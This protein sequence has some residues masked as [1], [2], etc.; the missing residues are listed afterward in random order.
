MRPLLVGLLATLSGSLLG[1][2]RT[3]SAPVPQLVARPSCDQAKRMVT[4]LLTDPAI[5]RPGLGEWV[6][7]QT[8]KGGPIILVN[9]ADAWQVGTSSECQPKDAVLSV[10]AEQTCDVLTIGDCDD[11]TSCRVSENWRPPP[12]VVLAGAHSYEF[13]IVHSDF[14][15]TRVFDVYHRR[16]GGI[17]YETRMDTTPERCTCNVYSEWCNLA[18]CC[19][20]ADPNVKSCDDVPRVD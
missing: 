10:C 16:D 1:C 12:G 6:G 11:R 13:Q 14:R 3:P 8:S 20:A 15:A 2:K 9:G 19:T 5:Q 4:G 17:G 18:T 7:I